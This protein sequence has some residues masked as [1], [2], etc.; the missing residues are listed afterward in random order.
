[1]SFNIL[2][3]TGFINNN[4]FTFQN[5]EL[6]IHDFNSILTSYDFIIINFYEN[7]FSKNALNKYRYYRDVCN[8]QT[9]DYKI[10]LYEYNTLIFG[11]N[12]IIQPVYDIIIPSFDQW[13]INYEYLLFGETEIINHFKNKLPCIIHLLNSQM[14]ENL[15]EKFKITKISND[16]YFSQKKNIMIKAALKKQ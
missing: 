5:E 2:K 3:L 8:L 1:M 4:A 14:I 12:K 13:L 16:L 11:N 7:Y 9:C 6:N 15:E 10:V